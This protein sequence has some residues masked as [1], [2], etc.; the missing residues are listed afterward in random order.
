MIYFH[1]ADVSYSFQK[2]NVLKKWLTESMMNEGCSVE[3][4]DIILCSDS[5]LLDINK[6]F[7]EHDYFTDIITFDYSEGKNLIG[8]LYISVDRVKENAKSFNKTI[9]NELCRV[10]IHGCLHLAGYKDKSETEELIMREK[11]DFYLKRIFN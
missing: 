7:L 8:E 2:K 6:K 4:I 1:N 9:Y 3:K 11:E 10:F 5:Y